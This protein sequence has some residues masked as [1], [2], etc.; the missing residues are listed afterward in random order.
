VNIYRAHPNCA[1]SIKKRR[2][3]DSAFCFLYN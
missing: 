3:L 1:H 2:V